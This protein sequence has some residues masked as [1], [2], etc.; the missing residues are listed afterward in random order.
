MPLTEAVSF[1]TRLQKGNRVQA[2]K[3]IRW[4]F[5]LETSQILKVPVHLVDVRM[6]WETFYGKMDKSG[7][8]TIPKLRLSLLQSKTDNNKT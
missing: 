4:R 2:P 1:K 7:R 6:S 5:K 8:I 3:P